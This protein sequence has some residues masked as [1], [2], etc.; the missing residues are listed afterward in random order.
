MFSLP[1][2]AAKTTY[3]PEGCGFTVTLPTEPVT[4]RRCHPDLSDKCDLRTSYTQVFGLDTTLNIFVKCE[5]ADEKLYDD[6]STDLMR[7][8]LIAM[9]GSPVRQYQTDANEME[10]HK[11]AMLIGTGMATN[12]D[13]KELL[14]ISQIHVGQGSVLTI[15]SEVI[16]A[17]N[18]MA[19]KILSDVL[20]SVQVK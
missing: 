15:E 2:M 14:Y 10:N 13:G 12:S 17:A 5:A 9:A 18:D 19:D 7:T 20:H 3:S 8:T 1:A 11:T 6:Y 4:L 16:G